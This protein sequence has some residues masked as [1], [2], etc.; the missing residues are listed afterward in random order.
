M[1]LKPA[2]HRWRF[3]IVR[4]VA[5]FQ[6][7]TISVD[8]CCLSGNRQPIN[9]G[10][11]ATNQT[12]GSSFSALVQSSRTLELCPLPQ[13]RHRANVSPAHRRSLS[14][15]SQTLARTLCQNGVVE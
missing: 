8:S 3:K 14:L 7:D 6:V 10:M 5:R 9:L 13:L 2:F 15:H 11:L 1:M 12:F 4:T